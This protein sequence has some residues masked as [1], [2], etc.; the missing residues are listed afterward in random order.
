MPMGSVCVFVLLVFS[1]IFIPVTFQSAAEDSVKGVGVKG[2]GAKGVGVKGEGAKGEIAKEGSQNMHED[3]FE[4]S[5]DETF[6]QD[7]TL[8]PLSDQHAGMSGGADVWQVDD[9]PWLDSNIKLV[10]SSLDNYGDEKYPSDDLLGQFESRDRIFGDSYNDPTFGTGLGSK[11][12]LSEASVTCH[13][14]CLCNGALVD[15]SGQ[16]LTS[17]PRGIIP[18]TIKLDL[19]MNNIQDFHEDDFINMTSLQELRVVGNKLTSLPKRLF[20]NNPF[21]QNLN[22]QGNL[23]TKVPPMTF[24]NLTYLRQLY[25]DSNSIKSVNKSAFKGLHSLRELCL[26]ANQLKTIPVG[27][28]RKVKGLQA[29]ALNNNQIT[30]IPN[31]AFH[32]NV[33]L[34]IVQIGNNKISTIEKDAFLGLTGLRILDLNNNQ[35]RNISSSLSTLEALEDLN[36]E[37][38]SLSQIPD[39]MFAN[40]LRLETLKLDQNPIK[41]V[42]S[43]AF[44]N[45]PALQE[46]KLS[47]VHN[48]A[49][50]PNLTGTMNLTKI[51]LDRA[52]IRFIPNDLCSLLEKLSVLDVHSNKIEEF[53]AMSNCKKL[54]ILNMANNFLKSL[55]G[56]PFKGMDSLVDLTLNTNSIKNIPQDA[57]TGLSTLEYL[58]LAENEIRD[59]HPDAFLPLKRLKDLNLGKNRLHHLPTAGLINLEKLKVYYNPDLREFPAKE[60]FL[61][62]NHFTMA[63]AYHCCDFIHSRQEQIYLDMIREYVIWMKDGEPEQL[64][65][66]EKYVNLSKL[67]TNVFE[68][69]SLENGMNFEQFGSDFDFSDLQTKPEATTN[70]KDY[71]N[72]PSYVVAKAAITCKPMPGPFMP[73]DDLFGW[74]SLRCGVWFV[75]M[76]A[77]LGNG[78]VFFV[79]VTSK[80]KMDVPRFLICNLAMADFF[81]GI[82]LGILAIVD[83]STLGQFKKYAIQW[84]MS[85]SCLV[86]GVLGVLSSE[87]SVFTLTVIT[88]ERFYAITHAMQL[89]KRL[90]LKHAACIMLGGWLW[91]FSLAMMPLFGISDY[92]KF[93]V[94][95]PFEIEDVISKSYVC[96][97]M[98][99]NGISFFIILSCYLIMYIS[100]RD[101]QAWNSNDTRVAKRMALLVFTDFL[102]WA[103]IAFLSLAAAFGKNL[104]H[105]N[106]AKVLTIFVLPLNSCANPFLY[107][108]F[109]KQFK[110]DCVLL[111]RRLEDS[112]IARHFS[113]GSQRQASFSWKNQ[114]R[115]SGLHS[116]MGEG[117]FNNSRNGSSGSNSYGLINYNSE[118]VSSGSNRKDSGGGYDKITNNNTKSKSVISI[119]SNGVGHK[120]RYKIC[121]GEEDDIEDIEAILRKSFMKSYKCNDCNNSDAHIILH[122]DFY[123]H[124]GTDT[125][126]GTSET[127]IQEKDDT[128]LTQNSD[129][130]LEM[131]GKCQVTD[132]DFEDCASHTKSIE[133][134]KQNSSP[135]STSS[136][137]KET[138]CNKRTEC[139]NG[140]KQCPAS[141]SS[142]ITVVIRGSQ[143]VKPSGNVQCSSEEPDFTETVRAQKKSSFKDF[144]KTP[145]GESCISQE[146]SSD[147]KSVSPSIELNHFSDS[148]NGG[149][150]STDSLSSSELMHSPVKC[151]HSEPKL[152]TEDSTEK[153]HKQQ[154]LHQL[155]NPIIQIYD[156]DHICVNRLVS[157]CSDDQVR[158]KCDFSKQRDSTSI[159]EM[160]KHHARDGSCTKSRT[161]TGHRKKHSRKHCRK[162][163]KHSLAGN[164]NGDRYNEGHQTIQNEDQFC[165]LNVVHCGVN[166][167]Q[168]ASNP[169]T[170]ATSHDIN[171]SSHL[172]DPRFY[173]TQDGTDTMS[174]DNQILK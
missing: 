122:Q 131:D 88:L 53:P 140:N 52:N 43:N 94:C 105:L 15:C 161:S 72:Q 83:A 119:S 106:E 112:S 90:S 147:G 98:V 57:F 148:G 18:G 135:V 132:P 4:S 84:Q 16:N 170:V 155:V 107:A 97:I 113:Q 30:K 70:L 50:F 93:A 163:H 160:S 2:E 34:I 169:I 73:C 21:L 158:L 89:N 65:M 127:Y 32:K 150:L 154:K 103:P 47:E 142:G 167:M 149:E 171:T 33:K 143:E 134:T 20:R 37:N 68:N 120:Y 8:S 117:K 168:D 141:S 26:D 17:V 35:I 110:R 64:A 45:L 96:F 29:L 25:L 19:S 104:I 121:P 11:S 166:E 146:L 165:Q 79:S 40:K 159:P 9:G 100:I 116:L 1:L 49:M 63:Y 51:T 23:F 31:Q 74:W 85:A 39:A 137:P 174:I 36:L 136:S 12:V 164:L 14:K 118:Q 27:A 24:Q 62:V 5:D 114:R 38:N 95:L 55:D 126:G 60:N 115:L 172:N 28:L 69:V 156:E 128:N 3:L 153:D 144:H 139:S 13:S 41:S 44:V 59:I 54:T 101:S 56:Q 92:R 152:W 109:T 71:S 46:L 42:S 124:S 91:S 162:H 108:F 67:W 138:C 102:C 125:N 10:D 173:L 61:N 77:L 123:S 129:S 75:F 6:W 157:I 22:F 81:M 80:S 82:Y 66:W 99:F 76:L 145:S 86:A 151:K 48:M 111:C 58:N 78:V 87:L 7:V 130:D 133:S